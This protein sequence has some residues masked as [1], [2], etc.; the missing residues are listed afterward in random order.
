V[1]VVILRC[2]IQKV[3]FYLLVCSGVTVVHQLLF[4]IYE[5]HPNSSIEI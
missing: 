4:E 5:L 1:Y 2:E 3:L